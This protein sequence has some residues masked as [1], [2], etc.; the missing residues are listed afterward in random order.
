[1][2]WAWDSPLSFDPGRWSP[3]VQGEPVR[4]PVA[5]KDRPSRLPP[6]PPSAKPPLLRQPFLMGT[7]QEKPCA[8][9]RPQPTH[10]QPT[11]PQPIQANA[12]LSSHTVS[13][14]GTATGTRKLP[15]HVEK[16]LK[17]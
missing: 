1:M 13:M 8:S 12:P 15:P 5:A 3:S 10:P 17:V 11:H 2:G 6:K 9:L 14:A 16:A 4:R 7:G